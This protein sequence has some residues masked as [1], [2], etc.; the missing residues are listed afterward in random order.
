M[1]TSQDAAPAQSEKDISEQEK[2][3]PSSLSDEEK[4]IIE[5]QIP[6]PGLKVGYF[7]L[8]RYANRKQALI[9]LMSMIAAIALVYGNFAGSF[10]RFS[11]DSVAQEHF[12]NQ[13]QTFALYFIYFGIASF[14]TVYISI[15]GLCYR[16]ERITQQIRERYFRAIFKQNIAFFDF[17]GSGE[18]TTRTSSDMNLVQNGV[19]Q[20]V[21]LFVSGTSMFI[22]ALVVGFVRS[23]KLTLIMLSA[24]VTIVLVMGANEKQM[25]INQT[26]SIDEYATARSLAEEVLSSARN[27]TAF[28]TQKRLQRKYDTFLQRASKFDF[29]GKIWL[30]LMIAGNRFLHSGELD[31]AQILTV[32]MAAMIAG[33]SIGRYQA[34]AAATKVFHTIERESPIDP[35]TDDGQKPERYVRN[36]EFKDIKHI[37]PSRVDTTVPDDFSFKIPAGKMTAL[38]GASG[39]GKSTIFGLLER[40]YLP[41]SGQVFLDGNDICT[42]NSKWLRRRWPSISHG[43]IGSEYEDAKED[44]KTELIQNAARIANAYDFINDLSEKFQTKAEERGN[45]LSCGQKQRITISRAVVSDPK[46]MLLDEATASLD[47]KSES[48]IQE[49]LDRASEDNIVVI[50]KGKIVE[51]G[52]RKE[53]L[54]LHSVYHS[55]MTALDGEDIRGDAE[56][57][58]LIRTTTTKEASIKPSKTHNEEEYSTWR[59]DSSGIF[60]G[61]S[62]N[63]LR[64]PETTTGG[65]SLS[66][67]CYMFLLL[68]MATSIFYL[69][70]AFG[71]ILRQDIEFFDGDEVTSGSL[72]MF[73]SSE[74]N[75]LAGLSGSTLGTV[76]TSAVT[77]FGATAVGCAFGWKLALVCTSTIPI[78]LGCGYFRFHALIR[79]EKRMKKTTDAASFACEAASF[80]PDQAA[81]NLRSTNFSAIVYAL[82]QS[83]TL[84]IMALVFWYGG[85]LILHQ[86][87]TVVQ[88]FVCFASIING[89]QLAG[90]IFSFAPGMGEARSAAKLLKSFLNCV[91]RLEGKV[92]LQSVRFTYAGRPDHTVLRGVSLT[93]E[94]G[95]FI[96]LNLMDLKECNIQDHRSKLAI[97]SQETTL[98]TETIRGNIL[99]DKEDVDDEAIVQ[100]SNDANIYEFIMS[101]PDG[102]KTLFD[103][104]YVFDQGKIVERGRHEELM[105]R[106]GGYWELAKLQAMS[107]PQ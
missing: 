107:A 50:T 28:R 2:S 62:I 24:T 39:S 48:A 40:F 82:S 54:G 80:H 29:K 69:F 9:M 85:T 7:S 52:T 77:V 35:E 37:Y 98:Y 27:I 49:A 21:A 100:A 30:S 1:V 90:A 71:S 47:T 4:Q 10:T 19:G 104:I 57:K 89:A 55:P 46:I 45:L 8:F 76:V 94:P 66:F 26:R 6:V 33:V 78:L 103:D 36:I 97:V 95:Q 22:S 75:R 15:I 59:L 65:H 87:Y 99:A 13:I 41:M 16:G 5:K 42:L 3:P 20:K 38:V 25:K 43:L 12:R 17:L 23:W 106:R 86:E 44:V 101:L 61:N 93:A 91:D 58:N 63:A 92:E 70:Q 60:L 67:W 105:G 79:M 32:I 81:G 64:S 51:Q 74:A 102:V 14:V 68:G 88:F 31:V 18:I 73:L 11:A 72:A 56:K 84:F 83:L 34:T 53:L 96:A